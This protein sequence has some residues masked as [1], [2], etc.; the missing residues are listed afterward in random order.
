MALPLFKDDNQNFML[1]QSQ[2]RSQLNPLLAL[3]ILNGV[4]L[5]NQ[6]LITGANKINHLLSRMQTGWIITDQNA[7]AAQIYRSQPFNTQTLTLTSSA[8]VIIS[9]WVF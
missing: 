5:Q 6:S 7:G 8:P 1:M 9:L 2:W 3:P 4:L